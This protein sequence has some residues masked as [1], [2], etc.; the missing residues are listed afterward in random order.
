MEENLNI[1]ADGRQPEYLRQPHLHMEVFG[2]WKITS[3]IE[4]L[5][6]PQCFGQWKTTSIYLANGR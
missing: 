2:I 4:N 1:L 3:T 6:Q 5:R